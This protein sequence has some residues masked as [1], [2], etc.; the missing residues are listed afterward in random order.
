MAE[1]LAQE[2]L[3]LSS[4]ELSD[5]MPNKAAIIKGDHGQI[6]IITLWGDGHVTVCSATDS[7]NKEEAEKGTCYTSS[8]PEGEKL[9]YIA[10]AHFSA[11]GHPIQ[12]VEL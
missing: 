12:D 7:A 1:N 3:K 9:F 4:D 5:V 8:T 6:G 2:L 11:L 10:C